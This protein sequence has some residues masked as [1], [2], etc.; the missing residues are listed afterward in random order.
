[1]HK[2]SYQGKIECRK[3]ISLWTGCL[4]FLF[5][6]CVLFAVSAHD[7]AFLKNTAAGDVLEHRG[8]Y[9]LSQKR[10]ARNATYVFALENGDKIHTSLANASFADMG[11]NSELHFI[12][13]SP[14]PIGLYGYRCLQIQ[15]ID[16][17]ATYLA[18]DTV[19]EDTK[20]GIPVFLVIAVAFGGISLLCG[21]RL[22][23]GSKKRQSRWR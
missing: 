4:V 22:A 12:Y 18:Q 23:A 7:A 15:S 6:A 16:G 9:I 17:T 5:V 8:A 1:M 20:L 13:A 11:E 14:K 10:S 21:I 19:V 2:K 3:K